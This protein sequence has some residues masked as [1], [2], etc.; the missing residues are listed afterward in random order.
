MFKLRQ[1]A[2]N[3]FVRPL[4]HTN[5]FWSGPTFGDSRSW[6]HNMVAQH[7]MSHNIKCR[8]THDAHT[9]HTTTTCF[10]SHNHIV[11][12]RTTKFLSVWTHLY[13]YVIK[14]S[15]LLPTKQPV[16]S[17]QERPITRVWWAV[18]KKWKRPFLLEILHL[19]IFIESTFVPKLIL[20]EI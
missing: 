11:P 3:I 13:C 6:S 10:M 16:L 20:S 15:L 18:Q 14:W 2:H 7:K 12:S 17:P 9:V 5:F 4:C 19:T 8:T 1:R